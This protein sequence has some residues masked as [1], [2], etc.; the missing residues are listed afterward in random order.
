MC[1]ALDVMVIVMVMV[2]VMVVDNAILCVNTIR[3]MRLHRRTSPLSDSLVQ[4]SKIALFRW[5]S[6]HFDRVGPVLLS[7][8]YLSIQ[9]A[10][11]LVE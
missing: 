10:A 7:I 2:M 8:G 3:N 11:P 9:R 6:A 5:L 1:N 4:G